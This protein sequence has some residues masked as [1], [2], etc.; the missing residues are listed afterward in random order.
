MVSLKADRGVRAA[1]MS[2]KGSKRRPEDQKK[3][4]SNWDNIFKKKKRKKDPNKEG[5]IKI[6]NP[7]NFVT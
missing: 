5:Y 6:E 3:I 2:G 1:V 7:R 4:E